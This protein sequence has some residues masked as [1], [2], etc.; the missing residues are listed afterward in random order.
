MGDV[1]EAGEA[2]AGGEAAG[3]RA[4]RAVCFWGALEHAAHT[5][6]LPVYVTFSPDGNARLQAE[7]SLEEPS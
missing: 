4:A 1:G 6:S 3:E 7:P 2:G 5:T